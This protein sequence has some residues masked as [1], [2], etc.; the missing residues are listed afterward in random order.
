MRIEPSGIPRSSGSDNIGRTDNRY[1]HL[2]T[3]L[4]MAVASAANSGTTNLGGL[5]AIARSLSSAARELSHAS[6]FARQGQAATRHTS[7]ALRAMRAVAQEAARAS[8]DM[9]EKE[10]VQ[11]KLRGLR[12]TVSK[13]QTTSFAGRPV[14]SQD[15]LH[16][17]VASADL[18]ASSP[19]QFSTSAEARA[20]LEEFSSADAHEIENVQGI[21]DAIAASETLNQ[22]FE[23]AAR[24]IEG[25][26][27]IV[28]QERIA[29][30]EA[31]RTHG[32]QTSGRELG[33][34]VTEQLRQHSTDL[35]NAHATPD[36]STLLALLEEPN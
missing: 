33:E 30:V 3:T 21:D 2:S 16:V 25:S 26:R 18:S 34:R 14:F 1:R 19:V 4:N 13:L 9:S 27:S 10:D 15:T 20:V 36:S 35:A 5:E 11:R 31:A 6:G 12:D 24:R 7:Q 28:A 29:N 22:E 8:S 23:A 17:H 32:Q